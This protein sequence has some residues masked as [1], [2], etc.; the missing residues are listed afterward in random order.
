MELPFHQQGDWPELCR[1]ADKAEAM[2]TVIIDSQMKH[3]GKL[4][5][6]R[7]F[8]CAMCSCNPATKML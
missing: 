4:D 2:E 3:L 6:Y 8:F 5:T 7:R 1:N